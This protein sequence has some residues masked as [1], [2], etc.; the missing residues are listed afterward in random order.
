MFV[1]LFYRMFIFFLTLFFLN[2]SRI[3][4]ITKIKLG[5]FFKQTKVKLILG[6][7]VLLLVLDIAFPIK[8]PNNYSTVILYDEGRIL[9]A[10]L[11]NEDKWRLKTK[12]EEVSPLFLKAIIAKEDKYFYYHPGVNPVA[13][14][15]AFA[16]NV[17]KN[18]RVSGASTITMQVIRM[19]YPDERTYFNKFFEVIRAIQLELHY[20][21]KEI[22]GLYL[23]LIPFGSN[24]EGIKA[25]T[26]IYL[27]KHPSQLS[28]A[29]AMVLSL[30]PNK[31]SLLISGKNS[32]Q[33]K[34]FK[35]KWLRLFEKQKIFNKT[36]I[37]LA[38]NETVVLRR[39]TFPRRAPH[40]SD[41]LFEI[42]SQP[43]IQS[44]IHSGYQLQ[45]EKQISAYLQRLETIGVKNGM[46]MVIDNKTMKVL[47]YCGS[48]DYK[49]R[50]D[51]GQVDGI[52]AIRSPGSAL[53]PYLY[54]LSLEK[55]IIN[56]K[57]ILYDIPTDFGGFKPQNFDDTFQGQVNMQNA[58]QQSLNIPAVKTLDEYGLG[59][60]LIDMKKADFKSIKKNEDKLG[61]SAILG[62]CG[63]SMEEMVRLYATFANGG[64][65]Q[66]LNFTANS[67]FSKTT[68]RE[69]L[70][71]A[72]CYIISDIL[73][74]I[75]RPDFP[76]NFDFTFRLPKI[77]WKTG[78]SFGKRDAWAIG[79]NPDY[80]VGLWLGNFSGESI[81]QLSGAAVAT[82][83]LFQIFNTIE[84]NKPW[85]KKPENLVYKEVCSMSGLPKNDFCN[86]TQ[87]DVFVGNVFYK[88]KCQHLKKVWVNAAETM[89]FCSYC[90]DRNAAIQKGYINYPPE[91]LSF[92]RSNGLPYAAPP[93]HNLNCSHGVKLLSLSII[94]P[95]NKGLY[96]IE[97]NNVEEIE[98]KANASL[99]TENVFWY[100]NN[101][102]VGKFNAHKSV[103][104]KPELGKNYITCTDE[105]GE[106]VNVWFEAKGL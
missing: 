46:A 93:P 85:F 59:E 69:L 105:N 86:D 68:A 81:P 45:V 71:P 50:I 29:Q 3:S 54:A 21:K 8:N 48:A 56:P 16:S 92:L 12:V 79:Y 44:T 60:F 6:I 43:Y 61:L 100:H 31:P 66:E 42:G 7:L 98:L 64:H 30:V 28:L 14:F 53:K 13:I 97:K 5:S 47:V 62:G 37:A 95:R 9:S 80:T 88:K 102:L 83:L 76:N 104:I 34:E 32:I 19:I 103:F 72:S 96:Y 70:D 27:Q 2:Q 101:R 10:Y 11:N 57:A 82:P 4:I 94:S 84:K 22:L 40:L 18:K 15:R 17:Q 20:S 49:N 58:L 106:S 23:N 91:Y 39:T 89:S 67:P 77:A 33:L 63:V 1:I 65:F 75:Q 73:S 99:G 55:G 25:A 24:I 26:Y 78:T 35:D 41:R 51:G 36:E 38:Q 87:I 74:G 52:R 90:L